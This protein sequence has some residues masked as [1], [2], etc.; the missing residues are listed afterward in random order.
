MLRRWFDSVELATI[1]IHSGENVL[2]R[3]ILARES[4]S[5][6]ALLHIYHIYRVL[7]GTSTEFLAKG[8]GPITAL[9]VATHLSLI[10]VI[11]KMEEC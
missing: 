10:Y 1:A 8:S 2:E 9:L 7:M 3:G 4:G 5:I 11:T 6:T